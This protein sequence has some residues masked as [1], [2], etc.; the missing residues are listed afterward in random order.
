[1]LNNNGLLFSPLNVDGLVVVF[2]VACVVGVLSH[3]GVGG[4][5][6]VLVGLG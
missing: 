3:Y 2:P 1:M 5:V 6:V 4:V